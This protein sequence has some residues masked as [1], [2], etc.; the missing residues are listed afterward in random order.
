MTFRIGNSSKCSY[1]DKSDTPGP[2]AYNTMS[3]TNTSFGKINKP[4]TK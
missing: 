3:M 4:S 2:G 1:F